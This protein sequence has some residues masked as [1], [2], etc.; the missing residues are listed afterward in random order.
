[1]DP[2]GAGRTPCRVKEAPAWPTVSWPI[3][4]PRADPFFAHFSPTGRGTTSNSH[5]LLKLEHEI[6]DR[7]GRLVTGEVMR[8]A[9]VAPKIALGNEVEARRFDFLSQRAF[10]D[11][12][13][14]FA[15]R[16][17]LSR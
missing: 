16:S 8:V 10:L 5:R 4:A 14:G 2:A 17:S 3:D 13:Q 15:D 1:M 11:A 12:M 9:W 7:H 6:V